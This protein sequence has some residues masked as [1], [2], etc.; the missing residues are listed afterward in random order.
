MINSVLSNEKFTTWADFKWAICDL[1]DVFPS[2]FEPEGYRR[3]RLISAQ[4]IDQRN[5]LQALTTLTEVQTWLN[6]NCI[7]LLYV[8]FGFLN[9][10][11]FS[12]EPVYPI[13][14]RFLN[15]EEN[16]DID[17][18][19][20]EAKLDFINEP[21]VGSGWSGELIVKV[22]PSVRYDKNLLQS[23]LGSF[24][25]Y[26]IDSDFIRT[27]G[28]TYFRLNFHMI[29]RDFNLVDFNSRDWIDEAEVFGRNFHNTDA[30]PEEIWMDDD[31]YD[32]EDEHEPMDQADTSQPISNNSSVVK[33]RQGYRIETTANLSI[34]EIERW[35]KSNN[36][37]PIEDFY[38][39]GRWKNRDVFLFDDK[40][41]AMLFKL[42]FGGQ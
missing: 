14:F 41:I 18:T 12:K 21:V 30:I 2:S 19:Y 26:V 37:C 24:G 28:S 10:D 3:L 35:I 9:T 23:G 6:E 11:S 39:L 17:F 29:K 13:Q 36:I 32:D 33:C 5:K 16:P 4:Y 22:D 31:W 27:D 1:R 25:I 38:Y 15:V 20:T 40:D 34:F 7:S 8:P 42:T